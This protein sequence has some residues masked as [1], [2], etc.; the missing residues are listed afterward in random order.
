MCSY[1]TTLPA[2]AG[3][4]I[5][6]YAKCSVLRTCMELITCTGSAGSATYTCNLQYKPGYPPAQAIKL[7]P[8]V[9]C[10]YVVRY[11]QLVQD[12]GMGTLQTRL[13][14]CA[15][16]KMQSVMH[17]VH[18]ITCTG[19]AVLVAQSHGVYKPCYMQAF[20]NYAQNFAHYSILVCSKNVPIILQQTTNYSQII[21]EILF[22]TH[23][24][25]NYSSII[26]Y[27]G[28]ATCLYRHKLQN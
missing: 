17:N 5:I 16:N 19:S 1:T 14:A 12:V 23:Y 18:G 8:R 6:N 20:V 2:C 10:M 28:L 7:M 11:L 21:L 26:I 25:Q 15:G 9:A 27:K 13:P 22:A 4:I 24:S 3:N